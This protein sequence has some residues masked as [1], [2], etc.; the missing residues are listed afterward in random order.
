MGYNS[1]YALILIYKS[2]LCSYSHLLRVSS[3][4]LALANVWATKFIFLSTWHLNKR[5]IWGN[6]HA[7]WLQSIFWHF[8]ISD[9][10]AYRSHKIYSHQ[11]QFSLN[12]NWILHT[13]AKFSIEVTESKNFVIFYCKAA[14][15]PCFSSDEST[16]VRFIKKYQAFP[17][18]FQNALMDL[19]AHT[20]KKQITLVR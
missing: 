18:S 1:L 3:L 19:L 17:Q 14:N 11:A 10:S 15:Y 20:E 16:T 7:V 13:M 9:Q 6:D 4:L 8:I 12:K 2:L 5:S